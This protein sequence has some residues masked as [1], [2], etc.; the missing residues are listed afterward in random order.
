MTTQTTEPSLKNNIAQSI[1]LLK[2]LESF[3]EKLTHAAAVVART[4]HIDKKVLL[5]GNGGSAADASHLATEFLVRFVNDRRP[6]PAIAL[7][8]DGTTL[9]AI[10]NDYGYEHVFSRQVRAFAHQDDVLIALSTSGNSP[11]IVNALKMAR[12]R[13]IACI[14]FLGK[15]GG[16]CK[17]IA[18][19]EFIVPSD[20]TARIQ[21]A[22]KFLL[23]TLCEMVED[24]LPPIKN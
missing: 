20:N 9:T 11:S 2:S 18:G 21:E 15:N 6:Y 16:A 5:C 14:A 19:M 23:H 22:H 17:G 1:E 7:A 8:A 3:E 10:G 13:N 12:N 24:R 4:L